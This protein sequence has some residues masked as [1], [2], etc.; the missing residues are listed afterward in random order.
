MRKIDS[1][2]IVYKYNYKYCLMNNFKQY[3][4]SRNEISVFNSLDFFIQINSSNW[5][6]PLLA[7]PHKQIRLEPCLKSSKKTFCENS[8][9]QKLL[10]I[11]VKKIIGTS[12][13]GF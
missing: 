2:S 11:F 7:L 12:L 3:H 13:T 10:T 9:R 5:N 6:Y 1:K 8:E 4:F